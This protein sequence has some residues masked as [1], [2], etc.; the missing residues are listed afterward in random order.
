M[1]DFNDSAPASSETTGGVD[2]V[3][4]PSQ[5]PAQYQ[6]APTPLFYNDN[7]SGTNTF[8]QST[9]NTMTLHRQLSGTPP[10]PIVLLQTKP[11]PGSPR[12]TSVP[13]VL[14]PNYF[15]NAGARGWRDGCESRDG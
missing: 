4:Q 6:L 9:P 2:D 1:I 12:S 7:G 8:I 3:V 5:A 10:A 15:G 13:A 14:T 11:G